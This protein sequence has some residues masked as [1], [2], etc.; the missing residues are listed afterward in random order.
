[1]GAT[2]QDLLDLFYADRQELAPTPTPSLTPPP[3]ATATSQPEEEPA[4]PTATPTARPDIREPL[5][6]VLVHASPVVRV[7]R[8]RSVS[9]FT[10]EGDTTVL[11]GDVTGLE[12]VIPREAFETVAMASSAGL[13]QVG[14]LSPLADVEIDGPTMGATL[15]DLLD[16]FYADRQELAPTPTPSLTPP[17]TATATSQ[18]EEAPVTPTATP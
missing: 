4:T 10:S 17:P 11:L 5:A 2:L 6:K 8:E 16:L 14:L 1:M 13:L 7:I 3:T 15:Q 9:S 18:P 12:V